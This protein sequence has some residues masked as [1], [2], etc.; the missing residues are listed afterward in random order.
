MLGNWNPTENCFLTIYHPSFM[1]HWWVMLNFGPVE[2]SLYLC[3]GKCALF[4]CCEYGAGKAHPCEM[5]ATRQ[6]LH[7]CW[8]D[9]QFR[10]WEH[11]CEPFA[12][13]NHMDMSISLSSAFSVF[14]NSFLCA[15]FV[16]YR[17][18]F[19]DQPFCLEELCC[20]GVFMASCNMVA[21][22][23]ERPSLLLTVWSTSRRTSVQGFW[24]FDYNS[25]LAASGC[26]LHLDN[27]I[28]WNLLQKMIHWKLARFKQ[29]CSQFLFLETCDSNGGKGTDMCYDM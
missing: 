2:W 27:W 23:R 16:K 28:L 7:I 19:W 4:H 11:W 29:T 10:I 9:S 15:P 17:S 21:D 22:W 20:V 18:V 6:A 13:L 3:A 5:I 24:A 14:L 8:Q 26:F 1:M 12:C 25:S